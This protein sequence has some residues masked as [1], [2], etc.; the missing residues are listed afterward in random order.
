MPNQL[1]NMKK[2]I[3]PL[4]FFILS[5]CYYD[6][7]EAL[8]GRPGTGV[9]DTTVTKFSTQIKPILNSNCNFQCHSNSHAPSSGGGI[10]LEDYPDVKV[11]VNN[12][13]LVGSI[14]HSKGYIRMPKNGGS[15]SECDILIIK[16]WISKDALDN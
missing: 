8:Y 5:G 9:C 2:L 14:E 6:S 12:G 1:K 13:K 10:K 3:L 7:E 4:V 15:L 16:T 11:Q